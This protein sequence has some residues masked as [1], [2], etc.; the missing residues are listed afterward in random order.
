MKPGRP[1]SRLA[2]RLMAL[3]FKIR[4]W[5]SPPG[6]ILREADLRPG[7]RVLDFGCGPGGFTL[8]A[9]RQVGPAGSVDALDIQPMALE[10]VRRAAA[11][12]GLENV[13]P[14]PASRLGDVPDGSVDR[15]LLYDVL[16][17][18][19][20]PAPVLAEFRRVL[21]PDGLLSVSDHHLAEADLRRRITAGEL[22]HYTGHGPR[23]TRFAAGP[24]R[25]E[26]P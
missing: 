16:H 17:D 22:F 15:V 26:A 5:L 1:S 14:L 2:F 8:A 18:I 11:R 10:S 23:T 6:E 9:A 3:E 13:R 20:E 25:R 24:D 4:D 12:H 21:K 19:A 7:M